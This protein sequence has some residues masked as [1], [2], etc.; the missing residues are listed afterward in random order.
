MMMTIWVKKLA[1]PWS[2]CQSEKTV[3]TVKVSLFASACES[4]SLLLELEA[5]LQQHQKLSCFFWYFL[6]LVVHL[7][8]LL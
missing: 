1:V 3:L 8:P 2:F 4:C 7:T 5:D 6:F